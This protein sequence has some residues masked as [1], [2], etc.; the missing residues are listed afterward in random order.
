MRDEERQA[1]KTKTMDASTRRKEETSLQKHALDRE[2]AG[3]ASGSLGRKE[4]KG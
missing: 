2:K 1:L 4:G 3:I